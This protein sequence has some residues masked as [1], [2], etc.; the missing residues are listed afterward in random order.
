MTPEEIIDT[1]AAMGV[2]LPAGSR[3]GVGSAL[4]QSMHRS[5]VPCR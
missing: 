2:C 4:L 1:F 3:S 5:C